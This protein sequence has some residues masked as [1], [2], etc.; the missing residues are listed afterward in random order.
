MLIE[1]RLGKETVVEK[2]D[3]MI[4]KVKELSVFTT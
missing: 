4:E 2:K 3:K 1:L